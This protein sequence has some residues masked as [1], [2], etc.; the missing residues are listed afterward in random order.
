MLASRD[1][2]RSEMLLFAAIA[3]IFSPC[4]CSERQ[5]SRHNHTN[6]LS[7][8]I[9]RVVITLFLGFMMS[10]TCRLQTALVFK[11]K[12]SANM[13]TARTPQCTFSHPGLVTI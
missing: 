3:P 5:M 10:A 12:A 13:L 4:C 9:V 7:I 1:A 6:S 2:S 8:E 11:L